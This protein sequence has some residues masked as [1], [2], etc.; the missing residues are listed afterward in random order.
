MDF[1]G[2]IVGG[3]GIGGVFWYCCP[4]PLPNCRICRIVAVAVAELPFAVANCLSQSPNFGLLTANFGSVADN[5]YSPVDNFRTIIASPTTK[6]A[7]TKTKIA[8][9]TTKVTHCRVIFTSPKTKIGF[10][11]A[12]IWCESCIIVLF[13]LPR[14]NL[15]NTFTPTCNMQHATCNMQHATCNMQQK[16]QQTC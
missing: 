11:R 4:L 14:R 8:S 9:A 5:N 15:M 13:K 2:G 10:H 1:G 12:T 7:A 6:I 16:W 3:M